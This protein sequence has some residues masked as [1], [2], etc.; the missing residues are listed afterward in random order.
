MCECYLC[1]I[2][3]TLTFSCATERLFLL[4]GASFALGSGL[5]SLFASSVDWRFDLD[6]RA[7]SVVVM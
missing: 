1:K 3:H 6:L 7:A 4:P 2:R 5:V